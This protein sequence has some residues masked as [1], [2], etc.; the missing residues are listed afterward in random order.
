LV[1]VKTFSIATQLGDFG[2]L[3]VAANDDGTT[4]LAGSYG[5]MPDLG[6]GALTVAGGAFL[7]RFDAAGKHLWSRG[8]G[9]STNVAR[10]AG[11]GTDNAGHVL[12]TGNYD[13]KIDFGPPTSPLTSLGQDIFLAK[14][15][16]P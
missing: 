7:A 11:V 10:A 1:W 8:V 4:T 3:N 13:G 15:L 5:G 2:I 12:L 6:G 14:L 16:V 9:D